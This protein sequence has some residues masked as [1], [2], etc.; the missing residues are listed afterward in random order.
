[1]GE[2][3]DCGFLRHITSEDEGFLEAG[4]LVI[5]RGQEVEGCD[6]SCEQ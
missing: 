1:M 5:E 3:D 6:G 2:G 4:V